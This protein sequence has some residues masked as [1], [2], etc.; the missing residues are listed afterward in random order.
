M[1]RRIRG[2]PSAGI[3]IAWFIPNGTPAGRQ[4][5]GAPSIG[6]DMKFNQKGLISEEKPLDCGPN[7][8]LVKK[9]G[10]PAQQPVWGWR[11]AHSQTLG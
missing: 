10:A 8:A 6:P 11:Q 2:H 5:A 7:T 1:T 3:I 4:F 9:T